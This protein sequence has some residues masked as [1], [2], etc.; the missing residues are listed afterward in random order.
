VTP[1]TVAERSR[2]YRLR[3]AGKLPRAPGRW[4]ATPGCPN[5]TTG[6]HGALCSRCWLKFTPEGREVRA[7]WARQ[8]RRRQR[9]QRS[10]DGPAA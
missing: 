2:I 4:C 5:Q 3:K 1:L 6:R 8:Q 7:E 10:R 9:E